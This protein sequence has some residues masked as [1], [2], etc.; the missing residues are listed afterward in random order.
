M[1]LIR[2]YKPDKEISHPKQFL[3]FSRSV[4]KYGTIWQ[5]LKRYQNIDYV[6]KRL[7]TD[8]PAMSTRLINGKSRDISDLIKQGESYFEASKKSDLSIKPLILYYG[9]LNLTKALIIFADNKYTLKSKGFGKES[10][11]SHGLNIRVKSTNPSDLT[12]RNNNSD[13]ISEFCYV[14]NSASI[15][16]LLHACWSKN[17]LNK[18]MRFTV[19]DMLSMHP[20]SWKTYTSYC[21][22]SPKLF[23]IDGGGFRTST[24]YEH[25]IIFHSTTQF[26]LYNQLPGETAPQLLAR[27]IPRLKKYYSENPAH[28]FEYISKAAPRSLDEMVPN[29]RSIAGERYTLSDA[30]TGSGGNIAL[31]PIEVEFILLFIMGSLTRYIPQKWLGGIRYETSDQMYMLEAILNSVIISYPKMILE[32]FE[33]EEYTFTGDVSYYS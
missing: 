2:N 26:P 17:D 4:D 22:Q 10:L 31:S 16:K 8:F 28:S 21:G 25:V 18:N 15:F 29:Y 32:E 5:Y 11:E 7:K 12:I 33:G 14:Q 24:K 1:D 3:N 30:S 27:L 9:M 6:K 23:L 19:G 13:L 20:S